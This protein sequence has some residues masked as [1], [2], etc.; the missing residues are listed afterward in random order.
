[1]KLVNESGKKEVSINHQD[2]S[3]YCLYCQINNADEDSQVL[4]SKR[5]TTAK[6]AIKYAHQ[7]G[8]MF[9]LLKN[10]K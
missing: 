7:K 1:M 10:R 3:Y 2:G 8:C 6:R 9:E 4:E 5:Y